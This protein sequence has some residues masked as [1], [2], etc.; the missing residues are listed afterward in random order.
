MM[1]RSE[2]DNLEHDLLR[3]DLNQDI[4][5]LQVA[6]RDIL[7]VTIGNGEKNLFDDSSSL[8]LTESLHALNSI[9]ELLAI[10]QLGDKVDLVLALIDLVESQDVRVV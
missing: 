1:R 2:I 5:W 9:K 7:R 6:M 8:F 4:L 3:L 10:A